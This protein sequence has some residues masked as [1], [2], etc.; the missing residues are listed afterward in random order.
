[1]RIDGGEKN[2]FGAWALEMVAERQ[3]RRHDRAQCAALPF[4]SITHATASL[5]RIRRRIDIGWSFV[6]PSG[7]FDFGLNRPA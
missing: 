4:F 3:R 1:V 2:Q 6:K 7:D 5:P